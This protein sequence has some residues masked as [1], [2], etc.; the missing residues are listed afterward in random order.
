ML[1]EGLV[2]SAKFS[3]IINGRSHGKI[4]YTCDSTQGDP[5]SPFLFILMVDFLTYLLDRRLSKDPIAIH[6]IGASNFV[7][8]R[9]EST[10]DTAFLYCWSCC[11]YSLV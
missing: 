1:V 11:T 9:L 2:L 6:L 4:I 7:S 3:I 10:Y 5:L 8:C